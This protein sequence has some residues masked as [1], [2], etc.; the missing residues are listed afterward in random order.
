MRYE[1]ASVGLV[2][3]HLAGIPSWAV[4]SCFSIGRHQPLE[5]L[6]EILRSR[7]FSYSTNR[8]Y[9]SVVRTL[10]ILLRSL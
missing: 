2:G 3:F 5:R 8:A 6:I 10:I 4:S 9:C 1:R 7:L